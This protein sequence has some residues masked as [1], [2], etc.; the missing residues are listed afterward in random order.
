ME[1]LAKKGEM[2]VSDKGYEGISL[3]IYEAEVG[4]SPLLLGPF[5]GLLYPP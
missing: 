1:R 5:I 3:F 4:S 2:L